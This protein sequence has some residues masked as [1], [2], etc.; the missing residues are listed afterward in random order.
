MVKS[1]NPG[2]SIDFVRN[3]GWNQSTDPI[4]KAYVNEVL[5]TE[6][7]NQ[8]G[9]Y[10][11]ILT[12]TSSA[13]M[14][15]DTGVPPSAIPGLIASKNPG[16][17]LQ[18]E[19]A[20]NPWIVFNTISKNNGGAMQKVAVRQALSYALSRAQLLQ[21]GG[22]PTVHPPQTHVIAA[23]TNGASPDFDLYPFDPTKAKQMLAAAG[24][25]H[26]SVKYLYR[27]ASI[28][29][30]KDFQ[31]VQANL[32]AIGVTVIPVTATNSDFYAKDLAPGTL[33][34]A[35]GWDLAEPGWGPDWYPT[36]DKSMFLPILDGNNLPPNSSNYGFF[37]DPKASALYQQAL[38]ASTDAQATS[39]WHQAD[40]EVMSQ[41]PL[42]PITN[43]NEGQLHGTQVHN[44]IYIAVVQNCDPTN[45]WLG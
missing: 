10:Q 32:S 17:S 4:R 37:S 27:P 28:A 36:G 35:G 7:G 29:S 43:P 42:F 25:T 14:M 11:Q 22:G 19:S 30:S 26:L 9:I 5:V 1:Y 12:N 38:T 41:A 39:L 15:W 45:I 34:K 18:S 3:P 2:K 23:G 8:Q 16:F 21:N 24:Y 44:C 33:A 6:T 20:D 40:M 13:D 31:T